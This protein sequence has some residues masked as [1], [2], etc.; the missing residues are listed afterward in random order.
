MRLRHRDGS[1]VHL[2]YCANAHPAADLGALI[3]GVRGVAGEVR[4]RLGVRRLG[5]GLWLAAPVAR[6]LR[7]DPEALDALR[8]ALR[9]RG[10]ETV[11]FNGF[12]FDAFGAPVVKEGVYRPDW[13]SPERLAYTL[14]LA[15]LLAELLPDD[16]AEGSVSTLPLG[17]RADLGGG[18]LDRARAGLDRL[19]EGLAEVA[20]ATGRRIRAA[21]EPEPGCAVETV[22]AAARLLAESD[23]EWIGV[24]LDTCHLAVQFEEP[25]AAL[26]ALAEAGV[27]VVKAQVSSAV[28]VADAAGPGSLDALAAFA[29]PRYLHQTRRRGA[30]GAVAGV[31]DLPQ[32]LAGAL[33]ADGEW[34]V[35]FHVPVHVGGPETTRG[36]LE[37]ALA[38]LIGGERPLTRHLE[39]ETYTWTA[40]PSG[41]RPRDDDGLADGLAAE[42]GWA[43]DHALSLG[44]AA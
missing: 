2:A 34:R 42:L 41:R 23:R 5:V 25:A 38:A 11:T 9:E 24:C 22:A 4:E 16:C 13:T 33:P 20:A 21:V 43:R 12:P 28:R 39:L 6:R 19:A 27:D 44:L 3:A 1:T 30:D 15:W 18:G 10:L 32:A 8:R 26:A 36:E 37:A 14:D 31:D 35:H 7:A 40:L 17:W 29:E